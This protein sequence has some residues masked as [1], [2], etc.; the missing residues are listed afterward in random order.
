MLGHTTDILVICLNSVSDMLGIF[1]GYV[2]DM[3]G[4]CKVCAWDLPGDMVGIFG[5]YARGIL[6]ICQGS[7]RDMQG[8]C[9]RYD[10]LVYF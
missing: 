7:F 8:I 6:G 5:R 10:W 9:S 1:W 4:M 2:K 3:P